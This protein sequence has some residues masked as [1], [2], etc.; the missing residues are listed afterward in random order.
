MIV[1]SLR[2][3]LPW[4]VIPAVLRLDST[5]APDVPW[6]PFHD[7]VRR[8]PSLSRVSGLPQSEA[9]KTGTAC[10]QREYGGGCSGSSTR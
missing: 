7:R 6:V 10:A 8:T 4:R 9:I 3:C 1:E 2:I 5:G